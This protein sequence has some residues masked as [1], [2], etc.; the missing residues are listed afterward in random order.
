MTAAHFNDFTQLRRDSHS[1]PRLHYSDSTSIK[2]V[3]ITDV[4]ME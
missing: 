1:L 3:D 4:V 2:Q